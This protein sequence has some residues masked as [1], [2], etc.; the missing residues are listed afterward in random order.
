MILYLVP[1]TLL[2]IRDGRRHTLPVK[3]CRN[4]ALKPQPRPVRLS[5]GEA[6]AG[7]SAPFRCGLV[8]LH[9]NAERSDEVIGFVPI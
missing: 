4:V 7:D 2:R 8:L 9:V 3:K 6:A 1:W 5:C